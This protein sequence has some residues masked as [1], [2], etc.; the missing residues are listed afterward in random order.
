MGVS[1]LS[2][3]IRLGQSWGQ[4]D[5]LPFV[6]PHAIRGLAS[7]ASLL[8]GSH[9]LGREREQLNKDERTLAEGWTLTGN[10]ALAVW[11]ARES[12]TLALRLQPEDHLLWATACVGLA[13]TVQVTIAY[14]RGILG[15]PTLRWISYLGA[16]L[17]LVLGFD[18]LVGGA[19]PTA[20]AQDVLLVWLL[21]L[22]AQMALCDRLAAHRGGLGPSERYVP[23]AWTI[24][25]VV[26][27]M[28]WTAR[29]ASFLA[30]WTGSG[31]RDASILTAALTS[32]SWLV[33]ASA[34]TILGWA[35]KSAFLRWVG[36]ALFG[37][38]VLKILLVDLARVDV[39]WR[40]L[41][42]VLAGVA[43]L[44]VSYAYQRKRRLEAAAQKAIAES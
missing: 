32:A 37:L 3:A 8:V 28:T 1:V 40:F 23:E 31:S 22:A 34:L 4:S 44:A 2:L 5:L 12:S 16:A 19:T 26:F 41:S 25:I 36:L 27:W 14:A 17:T 21:V 6:H 10:G 15:R 30:T 33:E 42:A 20:S 13:W 39:F 29:Q 11:L 18:V 7:I 35:R 24:G 38:L 9:V 43:L